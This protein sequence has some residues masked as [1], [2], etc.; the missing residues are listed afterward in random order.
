ML[1]VVL[2]LGAALAGLYMWR[3]DLGFVV[4]VHTVIDLSLVVLAAL[5]WGGPHPSQARLPA[6]IV[7]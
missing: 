4:V 7:P 3:R 6:T 1:G 5:G 2:P